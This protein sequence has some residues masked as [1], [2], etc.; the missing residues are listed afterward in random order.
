M[1]TPCENITA[2]HRRKFSAFVGGN[3]RHN[4]HPSASQHSTLSNAC[5]C[6]IHPGCPSPSPHAAQQNK[7]RFAR[8]GRLSIAVFSS[9]LSSVG[10]N[11]SCT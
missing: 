3:H 9:G 4:T 5:A 7:I 8:Y 10:F 1:H 6:T 11:A 2:A